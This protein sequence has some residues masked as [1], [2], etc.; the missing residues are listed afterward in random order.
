MRF[1]ATATPDNL[2]E[3]PS[4]LQHIASLLNVES[5][6]AAAELIQDMMIR[7]Q[8]P[9]RLSQ[10]GI[11]SSDLDR[12]I[13]TSITPDRAENNPRPVSKADVRKILLDLL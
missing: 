10:W 3:G 13:A 7:L 4:R 5:G 12:I 8:I 11:S 9:T 1:N 2:P 6:D